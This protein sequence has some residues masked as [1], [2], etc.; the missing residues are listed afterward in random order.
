MK[1]PRHRQLLQILHGESTSD[2]T[3]PGLIEG[4][5]PTLRH[6]AWPS[7]RVGACVGATIVEETFRA[8]HAAPSTTGGW[9]S[10]SSFR[11]RSWPSRTGRFHR[12]IW[13]AGWAGHLTLVGQEGHS[14]QII[15]LSGWPLPSRIRLGA[16][17]FGH[18]LGATVGMSA[19]VRTPVVEE[20]FG[21]PQADGIGAR[22]A[23]G[24]FIT[25][26]GARRTKPTGESTVGRSIIHVIAWPTPL[27]ARRVAN[28]SPRVPVAVGLHS[29]FLSATSTLDEGLHL[30]S[31]I[32][33][34]CATI[35]RPTMKAG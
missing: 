21:S 17:T 27:V 4:G 6:G 29:G 31:I 5:A 11:T 9:T 19:G 15:Q 7:T 3:L 14:G 20:A 10:T 32:P 18:M 16:N 8:H 26:L 1:H 22:T 24:G 35:M 2:R 28:C 33:Q 34:A 30:P 12:D 23:C 13:Q 25:L